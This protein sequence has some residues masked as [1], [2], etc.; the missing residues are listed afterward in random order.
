MRLR[1]GKRSE[2]PLFFTGEEDE[3]DRALWL[4]ATSGDCFGRS[5][6]ARNSESI[7]RTA[8]RQVPR[9]KVGAND[10]NLFR[11]LGS[12][13]LAHSIGGLNRFIHQA[14]LYVNVHAIMTTAS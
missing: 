5:Q 3:S 4:E 12:L 13:N 8:L 2:H 9:V 11:V 14:I 7:V 6:N 10:N 1:V